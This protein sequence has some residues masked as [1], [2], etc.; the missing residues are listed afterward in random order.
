MEPKH[1][2]CQ[3]KNYPKRAKRFARRSSVDISTG[4]GST[5][6]GVRASV[7]SASIGFCGSGAAQ[8]DV[9]HPAGFH[10]L[11]SE[12]SEASPPS[13]PSSPTYVG[14]WGFFSVSLS[15]PPAGAYTLYAGREEGRPREPQP[16]FAPLAA[17]AAAENNI[18]A[19]VAN[20]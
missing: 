20:P 5:I 14:F 8:P 4:G 6:I 17:M 19:I 9:N 11:Y 13:R 18:Q 15:R 3:K 16:W 2:C 12:L 10:Q 7:G 1:G